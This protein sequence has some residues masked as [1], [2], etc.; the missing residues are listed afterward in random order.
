[1]FNLLRIVLNQLN[2]KYGTYSAEGNKIRRTFSNGYSYIATVCESS[3]QASF[4]VSELQ[5]L[6]K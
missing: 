5:R 4:F 3:E 1:M 2:E 6:N